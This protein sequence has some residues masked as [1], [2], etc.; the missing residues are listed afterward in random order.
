MTTLAIAAAVAFGF[1]SPDAL[2]L[3]LGRVSVQS[4]LGEPLRAE[5][6]L[7]EISPEEVA[8]LKANIASPAQFRSAGVEFNPALGNV[9]ITLQRRSNGSYF[10]NLASDRPVN[11]PFVDVILEATWASGRVQRDFTLLLDPPSLRQPQTAQAPVQPQATAPS[12]QGV[13]S[14]PAAVPGAIPAP[15]PAPQARTTTSAPRPPARAAAPTP[16]PAPAPAGEAGKQVT[17]QAGDTA[18]KIAAANKP[19]NVSLDQMLVAMLRANPDAFIA[20]NVNRLR[21]GAVLEMPSGE[22]AASV[23]QA[24]ARQM[25][26][27]QSRDFNEFR[28]RLAESVPT[29]TAPAA[30]RAAGGQVQAEVEDKK[31]PAGP[32]DRLT[33]SKGAVQGRANADRIA[34]ERQ[35]QE[36]ASR[37]A[38]LNKNLSE[39]N[40][41][42]GSTPGAAGSR[43]AAGIT[44]PPGVSAPQAGAATGT[45]HSA[46]APATA[47]TP[48]TAGRPA[49]APAATAA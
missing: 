41:L 25:L 34:R 11:D 6:E 5:I 30:G 44:A 15:A 12:A 19:A 26:V 36:Q 18:G 8:S 22:Q 33:L 17:V 38:E 40:Q 28:R 13:P 47:T 39:L 7:P 1:A 4:A 24:E 45:A 3:A 9:Q 35:A 16:A 14:R 42:A 2:A 29:A 49:S 20:D 31:A 23:P 43:P 32:G 37:V 10:L 27:V 48:A 21:A 46:S